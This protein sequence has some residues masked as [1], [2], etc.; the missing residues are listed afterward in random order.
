VWIASPTR[1]ARRCLLVPLLSRCV[2]VKADH[3]QGVS[4]QN[5]LHFCFR[6]LP[7]TLIDFQLNQPKKRDISKAG[8]LEINDHMDNLP[9][10]DAVNIG[11]YWK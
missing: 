8:G 2:A 5:S 4:T 9:C 6:G 10:K 1:K 3:L 7:D 11:T